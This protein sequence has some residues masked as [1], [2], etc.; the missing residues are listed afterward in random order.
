[1]FNSLKL[2]DTI[3]EKHCHCD[4]QDEIIHCMTEYHISMRIEFE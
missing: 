3:A 2:D 1:M 4:D